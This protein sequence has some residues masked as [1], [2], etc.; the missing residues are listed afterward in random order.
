MNHSFRMNTYI[1]DIDNNELLVNF[2]EE[3]E[4]DVDS[5]E[6]HE[7]HMA[8]NCNKIIDFSLTPRIGMEFPDSDTAYEFYKRYALRQG[9]A[10]R[11]FSSQRRK[12]GGD[13][14]RRMFVCNK[15]GVKSVDKTCGETRHDARTCHPN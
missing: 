13:F 15:E 11:I 7:D 14:Y 10:T 1:E 2:E 9:F 8:S 3:T 4:Y 5:C 6:Q 12:N